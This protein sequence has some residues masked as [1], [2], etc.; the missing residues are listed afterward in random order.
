MKKIFVVFS[1]SLIAL[2][3]SHVVYADVTINEIMYDVEGTDTDREWIEVY[4][5]GTDAVDLSTWKFFE[6]N[7]NHALVPFEGGS[8]ISA[9]GYA[10]IA[11]KPEKF[12]IDWPNFS[13]VLFDSSFSL[14]NDPGEELSLKD[15]TLTIRDT[16]A[17]VVT[18][19]A[20]GDGN[21]LNRS[22]DTLTVG[23]ATPGVVNTGVSENPPSDDD[24]EPPISSGGAILA[25]KAK[26]T[27][28][29]VTPPSIT[30]EIIA[31]GSAVSGIPVSFDLKILG[32][33]GETLDQ[34]RFYI[35]FG[36]G[37][38]QELLRREKLSH[39]YDEEGEY[40]V[41]LEYTR[42]QYLL[43]AEPDATDRM[44]IKI[45]SPAVTVSSISSDGIIEITNNSGSEADISGWVLRVDSEVFVFPK[46]S[47]I[48]P[49]KKV[50]LALKVT[51]FTPG[52]IHANLELPTG[53]IASAYKNTP[54]PTAVFEI[55]QPALY[56]SYES[57]L[58]PSYAI[59][60]EE[61][62]QLVTESNTERNDSYIPIQATAIE[63]IVGSDSRNIVF[64]IA[65]LIGLLGAGGGVMYYLHQKRPP[66]SSADDF[67]LV[68]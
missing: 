58:A 4:N 17:Y 19:G 15:D 59:A 23:G 21:T 48:L 39:V 38:S 51:K 45:L 40:I 66:K 6:G 49:G 62:E 25:P 36:D 5:S 26:T 31:K 63:A 55:E 67:E 3:I 52:F 2:F 54:E 34:G 28:K 65:G 14:N 64:P 46:K 32:L 53:I 57:E 68:E 22:G 44:I 41:S 30:A 60:S 61:T 33:F 16:V 7:S 12:K 42:N 13:G 1:C 10:V 37:T 29:E 50:F 43:D 35:N 8:S 56:L 9:G 18:V 24:E 20:A 47:I 11:D 27:K